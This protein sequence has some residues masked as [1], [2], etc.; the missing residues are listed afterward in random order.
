MTSL[1]ALDA[2]T[3]VGFWQGLKQVTSPLVDLTILIG[4]LVAV[5][6]LQLFNLLGL[7][8]R[9][10]LNC[11]HHLLASGAV[12]F[13]AEYVLTNSGQRRLHSLP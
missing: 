13:T 10:D 7:C 8:W 5:M 1:I 11:Q 6:K 9:S 4:A 12:V 2:P 3:A